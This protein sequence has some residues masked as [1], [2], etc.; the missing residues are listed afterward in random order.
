MFT[1][2]DAQCRTLEDVRVCTIEAGMFVPDVD[3]REL[4]S[5]GH[6]LKYFNVR[7]LMQDIC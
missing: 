3:D 7:R 2:E 5:L 6:W 4:F 1:S